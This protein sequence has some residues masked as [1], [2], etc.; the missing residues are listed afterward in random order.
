MLPQMPSEVPLRL[1]SAIVAV[2]IVVA[3]SLAGGLWFD[4]V[5][6]VVI[7]LA[8]WELV[9]LVASSGLPL[10]RPIALL[11][12]LAAPAALTIP[13]GLSNGN[14][15][16][17]ST[18]CE[19]LGWALLMF[20]I[21]AGVG[22]LAIGEQRPGRFVGWGV[23]LASGLY[24]G[25][26]L[27]AGIL[28]RQQPQGLGWLIALLAATWL[29]DTSAFVV[30]R[31]WGRRRLLPAVS[32]GKTVEGVVGGTIAA[33]VAALGVGIAA[34]LDPIRA[35]GFGAVVAAG[36]V[37]G[38][39]AESAIKRQLGAKDSGQ[40]MPGHGGMLDRI[41]GLLFATPLSYA[42]VVLTAP[43]GVSTYASL[44]ERVLH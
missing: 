23:G 43:S 31:R 35:I 30:G 5:I 40:F 9:T 8:T 18:G 29:C 16:L 25:G 3:A 33:I 41:D 13:C 19:P 2:P 14:P 1:A 6:I 39:L 34:G 4:G 17:A 12:A 42:Y 15:L 36:A 32:P 7:L 11:A 27:S 21:L 20:A 44:G 28:L 24:V 10:L 37:V 38:D 22:S 26:L